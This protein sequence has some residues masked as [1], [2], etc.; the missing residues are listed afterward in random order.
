VVAVAVV[1]GCLRL[2]LRVV[3]AASGL[4]SRVAPSPFHSPLSL[5]DP[6]VAPKQEHP[7][8]N[9]R[10]IHWKLIRD[11]GLNEVRR[12]LH[13][14][15]SRGEPAALARRRFS[16]QTRGHEPH[17]SFLPTSKHPPQPSRSPPRNPQNSQHHW[18]WFFQRFQEAL[19]DLPEIPPATKKT[20]IASVKTTRAYFKPITAEE[21]RAFSSGGGG[22]AAAAAAAAAGG[23]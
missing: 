12:F 14:G 18:E 4:V 11:R 22:G 2:G 15:I 1:C 19:D 17:S 23:P 21:E 6:H 9:L 10:R 20:A 8:L 7:T 13:P 5:N 3:G 16:Q